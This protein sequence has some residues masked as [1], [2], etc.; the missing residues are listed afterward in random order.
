MYF[1]LMYETVEGFVEKRMPYRPAHL[2]L[3]QQ[4]HRDGR[5][6]MA[7]A[8]KP[9]GALLIFKG[10]SAAG[11]EAFAKA[12]PYVASG[13]IRSWRVQEWTVVVGGDQA[14]T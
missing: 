3:V 11:A 5:L 6:V 1:A 9:S 8:L 14:A 13:I 7:G 4:A 2:A 10:D 12:D